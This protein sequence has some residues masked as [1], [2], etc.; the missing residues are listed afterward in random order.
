M[1]Q[2][3]DICIVGA[4]TA[5]LTAAILAARKGF[6][7]VVLEKENIAGPVPRGESMA[8]FPLVDEILGEGFLQEIATVRPSFRRYHSPEDKKTTLVD[9]HVPYFFF[10][11][12]EF[13]DRFVQSA[14]GAGAQIWCNSEVVEPLINENEVCNGVKY[15]DNIGKE[16]E[17]NA[18]VVLAC[19]GYNS[20]LGSALGIDYSAINCPIM[21][22]RGKNAN[23][24]ID[25]FPN[26]QFWLIPTGDLEYAPQFPPIA[27]YV[28]PIGGTNIE[29]GIMLRMGQ[30]PKMKKAKLPTDEKIKEVWERLKTE[31]PGFSD[32][33]K[34]IKTEMQY[35]TEMPNA[36]LAEKF[37]LGNGGV[38]LIGDAAGFVDANGSSG[39]YYG[40]KMAAEWVNIL[41]PFLK[42]NN[43]WN[44]VTSNNLEKQF[45]ATKIYKHIKKSYRLIGISEALLFRLLGTGKSINRFWWL[46]SIMIK[47]AS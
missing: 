24:N 14:T 6:K 36:S 15:K 32:A 10:E 8:H 34:G 46:F 44:T 19:D 40:M 22:F 38:I 7:V 13:I 42:K 35:L 17:L 9:V 37:V 25:A 1:E 26:P 11:W 31:Y 39:L 20:T 43:V 47:S 4:G 21:K 33:F 30:V 28:F 5:G 18:K 3:C 41:D 45:R 2:D 27:A 29:A 23:I 12:R 16:K